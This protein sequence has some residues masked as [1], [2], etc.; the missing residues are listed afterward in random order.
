MDDE[1]NGFVFITHDTI[2]G[3][4]FD[5]NA[6]NFS[7]IQLKLI[8]SERNVREEAN[9]WRWIARHDILDRNENVDIREWIT[10]LKPALKSIATNGTEKK[11]F[12]NMLVM[13]WKKKLQNFS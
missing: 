2:D 10:Q 6:N 1:G 5:W 8:G 7:Q 13:E 9:N 4:F 11:A 3:F 12:T